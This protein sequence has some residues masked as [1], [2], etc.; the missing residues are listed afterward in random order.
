[1]INGSGLYDSNRFTAEQ[2]TAVMRASLRDFRVASE[3]LSSLAVAGTDGTL[4]LKEIKAVGGIALVQEPTTAQHDGMP[5]SAIA[6][7]AADHVLTV[8]K[9]PEM[10]L[11]YAQHPYAALAR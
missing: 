5:R 7:D 6:A 8:E 11:R 4:G 10:L 1:M 9:I 2:I 3:Y